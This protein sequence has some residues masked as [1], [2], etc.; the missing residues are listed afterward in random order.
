MSKIET[1]FIF[2]GNDEC[3]DFINTEIA[4]KGESIDLI[5]DFKS[6]L[7]WLGEMGYIDPGTTERLASESDGEKQEIQKKV[8]A[9]RAGLRATAEAL[10]MGTPLS[11]SHIEPINE[12]LKNEAAYSNLILINGKAELVTNSAGGGY[13]PLTPIAQAA[14]EL[15][16]KKDLSLVR[17]CANPNCP[18][19][20][21][22][23]SKNHRRR[24]CSMGRCG[25]RM[26]AALHYEKSK[27]R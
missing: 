16:T 6:L 22:D 15:L 3:L 26:K 13:D 24:W 18:L 5:G 10:S 23:G 21:Y 17:K 8:K 19:F 25:N 11:L 7:G 2:D 20:F 12:I 4:E 1:K 14:A 27:R 9:F